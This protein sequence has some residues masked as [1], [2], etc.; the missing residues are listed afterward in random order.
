MA[1]GE[2]NALAGATCEGE[3][4]RVCVS[5]AWSIRPEG[6][7]W[8]RCIVGAWVQHMGVVCW[9]VGERHM[10]VALGLFWI[11]ERCVAE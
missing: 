3:Y 4:C 6:S 9:F 10:E 5:A 8:A 11:E 2:E 1:A 7:V